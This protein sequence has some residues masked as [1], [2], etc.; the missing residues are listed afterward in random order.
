MGNAPSEQAKWKCCQ[1]GNA[2]EG[3][4]VLRKCSGEE[5]EDGC[6][7][8]TV[9]AI[10]LQSLKIL[11]RPAEFGRERQRGGAPCDEPVRDGA[12]KAEIALP[13]RRI[14][15]L[16][17]T[18]ASPDH[19]PR[20]RTQ[21]T[22]TRSHRRCGVSEADADSKSTGAEGLTPVAAATLPFGEKCPSLS[23]QVI[24]ENPRSIDECYSL[25]AVVGKGAYGEVR[26]GSLKVMGAVR[27]VKCIPKARMRKSV[28]CKHEIGILKTL[29]HPN[30]IKLYE[31]FEDPENIYLVMEFCEGGELLGGAHGRLSEPDTAKAMAQI[32]RA[33]FYLHGNCI[34]HR[35]LKPENC[36]LLSQG[37]SLGNNCCLRIA[38]FGLSCTFRPGEVL[39]QRV[40]TLAFMSP[41]V[42][43]KRY[44]QRCD[45][46]SCGVIM[47]TLLCGYLPFAAKDDKALREKVA[48]AK[49]SFEA[50]D[51]VDVSEGAMSLIS[52]LL[53]RNQDKRATAQQ[54]L[55]NSW[56]QQ[57]AA[58]T[59]VPV[60]AAL[61]ESLRGF[62]SLSKFKRAALHIIAS[63]L[64][65]EQISPLRAAFLAL[66]VNCDGCIS[67]DELELRMQGQSPAHLDVAA[68]ARQ[69]KRRQVSAGS[70]GEDN[71]AV[72]YTYTEFLAATFD[73]KICC[74]KD[75]CW[76]AFNVFDANGNGSISQKELQTGRV[77][78]HLTPAEI[79]RLMRD[80]D[81]DGDGEINFKEFMR[82]MRDGEGWAPISPSGAS[83]SSR[84][85]RQEACK[86]RKA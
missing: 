21:T 51:W 47:Y 83:R 11:G 52:S 22:A 85:S 15:A 62:R 84:S 67:I 40:G 3:G 20:Q 8:D 86:R 23:Q 19:C 75:I 18:D 42:I 65:E 41:E 6:L 16:D 39:K 45:L 79:E 60:E 17:G 2:V 78:G 50:N 38:D 36:L 82:M 10:S 5:G 49:V 58:G 33:V 46:W 76:A 34:C 27:A 31:L 72:A 64:S 53:E 73:R 25:G 69:R 54:A 59:E 32:F 7:V 37:L 57:A 66:D 4:N 80:F 26:I 81:T 14:V 70:D 1:A 71:V 68:A 55:R 43:A 77:L 28:A 9:E 63:L 56:V 74:R 44:N 61:I 35:D 48:T 12:S 13:K 30:V 24:I 29:D